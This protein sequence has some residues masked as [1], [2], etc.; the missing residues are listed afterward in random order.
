MQLGCKISR[1]T[2][3]LIIINNITVNEMTAQK[4]LLQYAESPHVK[5]SAPYK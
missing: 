1:P 3:L 5:K 2:K 4:C